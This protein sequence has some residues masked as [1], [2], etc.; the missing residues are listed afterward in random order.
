MLSD[1]IKCEI[2]LAPQA[3]QE[4]ISDLIKREEITC[5]ANDRFAKGEISFQD[6]LDCLEVAGVCIDEYLPV[7]NEN[8][9]LLGF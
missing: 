9:I 1:L 7:V 8:C 2:F 5:L 6:Y 3:S 4:E